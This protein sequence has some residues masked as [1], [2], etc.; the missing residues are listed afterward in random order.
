MLLNKLMLSTCVIDG[1]LQ[2]R[3]ASAHCKCP[4]QKDP[5]IKLQSLQAQGVEKG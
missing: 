3:G 2:H 1:T 5:A 4:L